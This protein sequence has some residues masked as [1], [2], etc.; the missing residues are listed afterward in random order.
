MELTRKEAVRLFRKQWTE[1]AEKG[2]D[3]MRYF[4]DFPYEEIPYNECYL[5]ELVMARDRPCRECPIEWGGGR[6][7]QVP[8]SPYSIWLNARYAHNEVLM[9]KYA[10]LISELPE[11]EE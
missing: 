10:K 2:W 3:K 8:S 6:E 4:G 9:A 11:R 1:M 5:C 7:C